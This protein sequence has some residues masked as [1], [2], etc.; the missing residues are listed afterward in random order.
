MPFEAVPAPRSDAPPS[1]SLLEFLADTP[2]SRPPSAPPPE[3]PDSPADQALRTG[4]LVALAAEAAREPVSEAAGEPVAEPARE[5]VGE[6]EAPTTVEMPATETLAPQVVV[7]QEEAFSPEE[8]A[9]LGMVPPGAPHGRWRRMAVVLALLCGGLLGGLAFW[10][11]RVES[12]GGSVAVTAAPLDPSARVEPPAPRV[13]E[14]PV[15]TP[16]EAPPPDLE[17]NPAKQTRKKK[18]AGERED[19]PEG[20]EPEPVRTSGPSVGRLPDL[21]RDALE[22][23]VKEVE[24]P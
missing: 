2:T 15:P 7:R 3:L 4:D 5:P 9:A 14:A 11:T 22:R 13:S 10:V 19:A 17:A 6:S 8:L 12:G 23:L 1:P 16:E 20:R 18:R 24:R 21:P